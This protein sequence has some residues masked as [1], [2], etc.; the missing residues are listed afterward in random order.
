[1]RV[2]RATCKEASVALLLVGRL[3]PPTP[4]SAHPC[5]PHIW[6]CESGRMRRLEVCCHSDAIRLRRPSLLPAW[7][8]AYAGQLMARSGRYHKS[9]EPVWNLYGPWLRIMLQIGLPLLVLGTPA[10]FFFER[11]ST[12]RWLISKFALWGWALGASRGGALRHPPNPTIRHVPA[13]L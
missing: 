1:M 5:S 6:C 9:V 12:P 11:G 2:A 7:Q 4:R 13:K 3:D 10:M 8:H